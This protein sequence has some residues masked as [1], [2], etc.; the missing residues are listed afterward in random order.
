MGFPDV[1]KGAFDPDEEKERA[2]LEKTPPSTTFNSFKSWVDGKEVKTSLIR[3]NLPGHYWH[4]KTVSFPANST[5]KIKDV[6]VQDVSGGIVSLKSS[7]SSA[8]QVAYVLHTGSSW[9]GTIGSSVVNVTFKTGDIDAPL[10]PV[11]NVLSASKSHDDGRNLNLKSV[12][13]G[14][15]VWKGP[16]TPQVRGRT[17][18]FERKNW[19]P[20]KSDDIEITYAFR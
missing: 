10:R 3:S 2:G 15:V 18:I 5:V 14:T 20:A 17:L 6:Y 8:S 7:Y 16:A 11:F 1:G 19:R 12:D 4:T 9:K 13:S